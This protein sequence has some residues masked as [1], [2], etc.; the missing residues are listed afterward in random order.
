MSGIEHCC[1]FF[2]KAI[3]VTLVG[4]TIGFSYFIW[5]VGVVEVTRFRNLINHRAKDTVTRLTDMGICSCSLCLLEWLFNIWIL[6][7]HLVPLY[8]FKRYVHMICGVEP[9]SPK[10]I[11]IN[12]RSVF[13]GTEEICRRRM[14]EGPTTAVLL[15]CIVEQLTTHY[16]FTENVQ[17]CRRLA[18][19][20]ITEL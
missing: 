18:V 19:G 20:I 14:L 4:C 7:R 16:G 6:C 11:Q 13:H 3:T 1:F 2:A 10:P 5:I 17:C 8:I 15:E 12:T 9:A